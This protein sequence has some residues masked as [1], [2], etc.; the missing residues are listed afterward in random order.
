MREGVL[1]SLANLSLVGIGFCSWMMVGNS[2]TVGPIQIG[3]G[4][5]VTSKTKSLSDIGFD[6][7]SG[8]ST[9]IDSITMS[10]GTNSSTGY[11]EP[12]VLKTQIIIDTEKLS[13]V[14]DDDNLYLKINL[15]YSLSDSNSLPVTDSL[16]LYP[17]NYDYFS[18]DAHKVTNTHVYS[19]NSPMF[20]F[21][22]KAKTKMNLYDLACLDS[23]YPI[24]DA[25][26]GNNYKVPIT[27]CFRLSNLPDDFTT[28]G[29]NYQLIYG[30]TTKG[31]E[32]V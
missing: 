10:D 13:Q 30:L 1:L 3:V 25:T 31:E 23:S 22:M 19:K 15:K 16:S 14:E 4:N 5:I 12:I 28:S 20:T 27:L 17:T 8:S 6:V 24:Y 26:H 9:S 21:P 11:P 32:T 7:V 29:L 18:F 2:E